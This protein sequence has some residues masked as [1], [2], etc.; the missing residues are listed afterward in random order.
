MAIAG[1]RLDEA[2][3]IL[4]TSSEREHRDGQ[5]LTDRLI[6]AFVDRANQHLSED[7]VEDARYDADKAQRFGG[8]QPNVTELLRKIA[9]IDTERRHRRQRRDEVLESAKQQIEMG[10]YT[11]G[12]RLL[13][14]LTEDQSVAGAATTQRLA[15]SL[16]ANRKIVED[17]AAKIQ[18]AIDTG[19]HE[20]AV[21]VISKLQT[22]QREHSQIAALIPQAIGP[23]V[24]QGSLEVTAGRL[25]RAAAIGDVL[26]S[27]QSSL[28]AV[29][30]FQQCLLRCHDAQQALKS[31]QYAVAESQ[32]ALLAQT[33]D[34][35]AW[36]DEARNA[37]ADV[38]RHLHIVSAG[39]LGLLPED[40][41][42]HLRP[43]VSPSPTPVAMPRPS[44]G[45][46][47]RSVLQVDGVGGLLL[48]TKDV[49]AIGTVAIGTVAS[50]S[51]SIDVRLATEGIAASIN[52]RRNGEDYF[53]ESTA[54]FAVNG[55]QVTRRLLASGDSIAVGNRGRL[56]FLKPVAASA[57]AVL[58][59]TGSR[60]SRRD[61]RSVVLM[62]DS[63]LFGPG[64]SHFRVPGLELPVVLHCDQ[65]GLTL[66]ETTSRRR[67]S[68]PAA[69][70]A[71]ATLNLGQSVLMKD[72]RFALVET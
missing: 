33:V 36:I 13:E 44:E 51:A 1:G 68:Q 2:F 62:A 14:G 43:P 28:P 54:P 46:P 35:A 16:E 26:R 40:A 48:L 12:S 52:M 37:V 21:T 63:L 50:S 25:D 42:E 3:Q 60:L 47:D 53:A 19:N 24:E 55:Q 17:A 56:K 39:P 49:V 10:A 15:D 65:N 8:R 70:T 59:I 20:A 22:D 67:G 23:L 72:T 27:V 45:L 41:Q 6:A 31:D 29:V 34:G 30:E 69:R 57:S 7:R 9:A 18:E 66:R 4:Q 32:L 61:I 5:R 11:A 38:T 64:G 71:P 58:Q